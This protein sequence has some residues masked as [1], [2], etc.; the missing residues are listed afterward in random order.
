M[1]S[2]PGPNFKLQV[3]KTNGKTKTKLSD[4]R[5]PGPMATVTCT[6]LTSPIATL[7]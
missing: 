4:L 5:P 7:F 2:C 1:R 3:E 6:R